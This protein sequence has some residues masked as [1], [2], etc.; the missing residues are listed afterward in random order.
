MAVT[1]CQL[2]DQESPHAC[3]A[4]LAPGHLTSPLALLPHGC[5]VR[6]PEAGVMRGR[7]PPLPGPAT[8]SLL[9]GKLGYHAV[10]LHRWSAA[11]EIAEWR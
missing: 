11:S 10:S 3:T 1:Y 9:L 2:G 6:A 5:T 8:Q 7:A 4:G